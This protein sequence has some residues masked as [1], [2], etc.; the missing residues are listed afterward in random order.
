MPR[1]AIGETVD[2]TADDHSCG[3]VVAVFPTTDGSYRYAI[4]A[5][6][7]GALQFVS[8]DRLITHTTH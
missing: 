1:F 8:E 7:Y 5:E 2:K 3:V 4:D 6:G